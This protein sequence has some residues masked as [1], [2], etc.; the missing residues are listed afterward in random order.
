MFEIITDIEEQIS[1]KSSYTEEYNNNRAENLR[2]KPTSSSLQILTIRLQKSQEK[3]KRREDRK[4][5]MA[6]E[7]RMDEVRKSKMNKM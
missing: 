7:N 3:I 6:E 1:D 2:V 4:K 5:K